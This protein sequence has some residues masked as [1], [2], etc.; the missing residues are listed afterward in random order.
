MY[1]LK[2]AAMEEREGQEEGVGH[3]EALLHQL[4]IIVP[5]LFYFTEFSLELGS[6]WKGWF[7]VV[8]G[9]AGKGRMPSGVPSE[10]T[11]CTN[12]CPSFP[13][14]ESQIQEEPLP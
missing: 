14:L 12:L 8:G 1:G 10:G 9:M 13:L 5:I 7:F 3:C 2:L 11:T 4:A 6:L